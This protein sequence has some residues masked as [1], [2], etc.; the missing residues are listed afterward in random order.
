MKLLKTA[1]QHADA[2]DRIGRLAARGEQ[3]T[4][5]ERDK[6]DVLIVLA[7]EYERRT[8]PVPPPTTLEAIKFRMFQMGYRQKDLAALVGGASRA[9]E[10]MTGK[11]GLTNEM[12]RRLRDEWGIPSD[13]LIG[14]DSPDPEPTSPSPGAGGVGTRNPKNYPTKQMYD[15]RYFP[16]YRDDW[17]NDRTQAGGILDDFFQR[18]T[19]LRTDLVHCRQGGSAKSKINPLALEAWQQRVLIRAAEEKSTLPSYDPLALNDENFLRWLVGLS[20][21]PEG[22]I[23]A[24]KALEEKGVAVVIELHLD[25]THLDGAAMLGANNQPIIGMTLRHNRLDNFWFTLFHEIC[26]V[27]KHLSSEHPAILDLDIDQKKSSKIEMEADQFASDTLIA[28][29]LWNAQVSQ[30]R[31]ADEIHA[32]AKRL[33]VSPAVIAGRLRREA[34]DYRLHRTLVGY[35]R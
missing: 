10:I 19:G 5:S 32:V 6:M 21:L 23:L 15:R 20:G 12:M 13:S 33:C 29:A 1:V 9:S 16:R 8:Q 14:F 7:E 24:C 31:Y 35:N 3:L 2:L 34:N 26:H 27:L 4:E 30:L 11:R 22:P 18:E 25:Q 28:P 17:K